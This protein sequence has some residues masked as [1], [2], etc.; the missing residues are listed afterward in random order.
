[1]AIFMGGH[2]EEEE[3]KGGVGSS[4]RPGLARLLMH[5]HQSRGGE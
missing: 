5:T 4:S 3:E 1:M 2:E